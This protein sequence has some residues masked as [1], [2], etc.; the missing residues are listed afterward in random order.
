MESYWRSARDRP[1]AQ[2]ICND[3]QNNNGRRH[4]RNCVAGRSVF[5]NKCSG[6]DDALLIGSVMRV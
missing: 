3:A 5:A 1:G 2:K 6:L 4:P